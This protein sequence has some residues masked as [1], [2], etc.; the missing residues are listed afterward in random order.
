MEVTHLFFAVMIFA[1][2]GSAV[3]IYI[4]P[5]YEADFLNKNADIFDRAAQELYAHYPQ[6]SP[7]PAQM[8]TDGFPQS[9]VYSAGPMK[10]NSEILNT[11]IGLP[12]KLRLRG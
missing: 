3:W 9:Q 5:R 10:R 1:G 8:P 12:A 4:E 6:G 11:L 7:I 2:Y